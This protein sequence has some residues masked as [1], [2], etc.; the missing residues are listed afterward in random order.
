MSDRVAPGFI[1]F[2]G[3]LL[4]T[5]HIITLAP[6]RADGGKHIIEARV[7]GGVVVHRG[8]RGPRRG[9][10]PLPRAGGELLDDPASPKASSHRRT[11][12]RT[13]AGRGAEPARVRPLRRRHRVALTSCRAARIPS[14]RPGSGAVVA[15]LLWGQAVEGSNPSSP[16]ILTWLFLVSDSPAIG[17]VS[18][19]YQ[20][21]EVGRGLEG[22]R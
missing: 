21:P 3:R 15:H 11:T 20:R 6:P 9:R 13:S 7:T 1:L 4:G 2:Q 12:T 16:T 22:R 10:R 18:A 19:M 8:V 5:A 17:H 14:E